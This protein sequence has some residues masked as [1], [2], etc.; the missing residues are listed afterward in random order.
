MDSTIRVVDLPVVM[1]E[2]PN[3]E[4]LT[5]FDP[6]EMEFEIS[7]NYFRNS[8]IAS[9]RWALQKCKRLIDLDRLVDIAR[10]QGLEQAVYPEAART[11][12]RILAKYARSSF[13]DGSITI[14]AFNRQVAML[15]EEKGMELK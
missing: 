7:S 3:Y 4:D 2:P 6:G 8:K 15:C 9:L 1:A 14:P 12:K 11:N 5:A 13:T 10:G